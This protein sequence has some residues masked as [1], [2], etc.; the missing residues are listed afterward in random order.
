MHTNCPRSLE[1]VRCGLVHADPCRARLSLSFS[2]RGNSS[3]AVRCS[4]TEEQRRATFRHSASF[5]FILQDYY[6][7]SHR[8]SEQA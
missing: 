4:S 7:E 5:T 2:A 6:A 1:A 3:C 8:G